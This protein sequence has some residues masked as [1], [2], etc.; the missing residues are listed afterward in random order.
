[1]IDTFFISRQTKYSKKII[2]ILQSQILNTESHFFFLWATQW[3]VKTLFWFETSCSC[4]PDQGHLQGGT[5]VTGVPYNDW[6]LQALYRL[7]L[8]SGLQWQL[9][10]RENRGIRFASSVSSRRITVKML[11]QF[12]FNGLVA[13]WQG[14]ICFD[15]IKINWFHWIVYVLEINVILILWYLCCFF[16]SLIMS[17]IGPL[18]FWKCVSRK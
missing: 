5:G 14:L 17:K 12:F 3:I 13:S 4:R 18:C 6:K 10:G 8:Q 15:Y 7:H 9:H 1:M 2:C 16:C 11:K